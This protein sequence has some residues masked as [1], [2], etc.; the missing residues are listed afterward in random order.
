M[1][2]LQLLFCTIYCTSDIGLAE[3]FD[4]F[5]IHMT[6]SMETYRCHGVS[7]IIKYIN[8]GANSLMG[9]CLY[10][11]CTTRMRPCMCNDLYILTYF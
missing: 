7:T 1:V 11:G 10:R 5:V 2:R 9:K 3:V 6:M 4:N 8:I